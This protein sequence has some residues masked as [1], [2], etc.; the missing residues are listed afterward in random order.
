MASTWFSRFSFDRNSP[1]VFCEQISSSRYN[2]TVEFVDYRIKVFHVQQQVDFQDFFDKKR[3]LYLKIAM[4]L[5]PFLS[6]ELDYV[7]YLH[8][9]LSSTHQQ[10]QIL[11]TEMGI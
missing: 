6:K 4:H 10:C 9:I 2:G 8:Q 7:Q 11:K 1:E 3:Q 5:T